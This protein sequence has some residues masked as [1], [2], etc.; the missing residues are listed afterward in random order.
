MDGKTALSSRAAQI[1]TETGMVV[2]VA[3]GNEGN[4]AWHYISAPSDAASVLAIGAVTQT[5]QRASLVHL[6]LRP[7]AA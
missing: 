5:G 4:D 3:A 6:A 1:A 7:M 2:V